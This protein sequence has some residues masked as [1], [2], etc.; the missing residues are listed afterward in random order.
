MDSLNRKELTMKRLTTSLATVSL[1]LAVGAPIASAKYLP[2]K[3]ANHAVSVKQ[4]VKLSKSMPGKRLAQK[5]PAVR[6]A[7]YMRG[8]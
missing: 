4:T 3:T 1:V 2:A 8:F 7:K 6:L 5:A